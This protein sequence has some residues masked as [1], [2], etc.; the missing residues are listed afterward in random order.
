ME[1]GFDFV[2]H[3]P[4]GSLMFAQC[5][6]TALRWGT[7][8]AQMFEHPILCKFHGEREEYPTYD[9]LEVTFLC[10]AEGPEFREDED[11]GLF[12]DIDDFTGLGAAMLDMMVGHL[13]I[14]GIAGTEGASNG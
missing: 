1:C 10:T 8:L 3:H 6:D 11:T 12:Y 2:V 5:Y 14:A 4:D 7:I 9:M 13:F